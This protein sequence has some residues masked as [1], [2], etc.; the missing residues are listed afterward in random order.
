MTGTVIRTLLE[1]ACKLVEV[2]SKNA[3]ILTNNAVENLRTGVTYEDM[4]ADMYNYDFNDKWHSS[5]LNT[6]GDERWDVEKY[7]KDTL[8]QE[9]KMN[10]YV[11]YGDKD[12]T[13]IR[14]KPNDNNKVGLYLNITVYICL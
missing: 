10:N 3:I 9:V 5:Q 1:V 6:G 8:T 2:K 7:R 13:N 11:S 4:E 12:H 14:Y